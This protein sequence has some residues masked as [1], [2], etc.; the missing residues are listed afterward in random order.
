MQYFTRAEAL[1]ARAVDSDFII[2]LRK[3]PPEGGNTPSANFIQANARLY[4]A[5]RDNPK[6]L[7]DL[8]KL[9]LSSENPHLANVI[10]KILRQLIPTDLELLSGLTT[11]D[12]LTDPSHFIKESIPKL[13]RQ[14]VKIP[15]ASK[16]EVVHAHDNQRAAIEIRDYQIDSRV[17]FLIGGLGENDCPN[18]NVVI[19]SKERFLHAM[20]PG[21][22]RTNLLFAWINNQPHDS[23]PEIVNSIATLDKWMLRNREINNTLGSSPPPIFLHRVR[24]SYPICLQAFS[25][26]VD[27]DLDF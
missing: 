1:V 10:G 16:H 2:A 17:C 3:P 15:F 11:P 24:D 9:D 23:L 26:L 8:A 12:I 21:G 7:D 13:P 20:Y 25:D 6:F 22:R 14:Y 5:A 18:I 19:Q 27:L 4:K